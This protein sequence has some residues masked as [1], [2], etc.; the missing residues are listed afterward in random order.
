MHHIEYNVLAIFAFHKLLLYQGSSIKSICYK[1][2]DTRLLHNND[3]KIYSIYLLIDSVGLSE[4][5]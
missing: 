2:K 1:D 5:L 4:S 3:S